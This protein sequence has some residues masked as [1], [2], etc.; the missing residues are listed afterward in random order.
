MALSTKYNCN[1]NDSLIGGA[2]PHLINILVG[3]LPTL[4]TQ[5]LTP[6]LAVSILTS[7]HIWNRTKNRQL[8]SR[9]MR[10]GHVVPWFL[11]EGNLKQKGKIKL[12]QNGS[13]EYVIKIEFFPIFYREDLVPSCY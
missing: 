11:A 1:C 7:S 5:F 9:C 10:P 4:P 12:H 2:Q 6:M 3:Q 8:L 13:V